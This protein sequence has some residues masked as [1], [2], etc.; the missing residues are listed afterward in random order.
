MRVDLQKKRFFSQWQEIDL[1]EQN[2]MVS[3]LEFF[4]SIESDI[5]FRWLS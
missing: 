1:F 4:K 5:L 2:N 3:P